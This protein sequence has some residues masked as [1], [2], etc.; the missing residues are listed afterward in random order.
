M[1]DELLAYLL[2]DLDEAQRVRVEERLEVDPIWQHELA[3]LRLLV[4]AQEN[5]ANDL[6]VDLVSRTCAF[7]EQASS[8]GAYSPAVLPASLT[9][10]QERLASRRN[11]WSLADW[12]VVAAILLVM[13][14]LLFPALQESR[15][16][17]R[18]RQ[19]Q[20]NLH[21][22]G[23]LLATYAERNGGQLPEI[24]HDEH[25]GMYAVKLAEL[26]IIPREQLA[27]LLL[28][29]SSQLA[30]DVRRGLLVFRIPERRELE[31]AQGVFANT[32]LAN[33][34]GS[35]AYRVGYT[36]QRGNYRQVKFT[37]SS[38]APVMADKPSFAVVGFQSDHHGC[39]QNVLFQ[40]QSVR[41]LRVCRE[42]NRDNHWFLNEDN[43]EAAGKNK[44]DVV[45]IRSDAR[46][47][48]ESSTT[49]INRNQN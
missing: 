12:G 15:E 13:G 35:F 30:D 44:Y 7:V 29:P 17:A 1:R 45:M 21:T 19:C 37:N 9:E 33:M 27:E 48:G 16:A 20:E 39:G 31:S 49:S 3:R 23:T 26:G 22:L 4:D 8:Q 10:S 36:D 42:D 34:G 24:D 28:C 11:T 5:N 43:Q 6:P 25:A 32:L 40:D 41:Y 2:N 14:S 46:P 18:R 47:L 38:H